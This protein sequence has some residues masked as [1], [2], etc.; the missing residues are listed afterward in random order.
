MLIVPPTSRTRNSRADNPASRPNYECHSPWP[1][2]SVRW[3][4]STQDHPDSRITVASTAELN[5]QLHGPDV[6]ATHHGRYPLLH[7]G[8][9]NRTMEVAAILSCGPQSAML[10]IQLYGLSVTIGNMDT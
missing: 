8:L 2:Y 6:G 10:I 5:S 7:G 4:A 9:A 3:T 1:T